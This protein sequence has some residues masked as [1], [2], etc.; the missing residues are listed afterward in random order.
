MTIDILRQKSALGV[1][2]K[3]KLYVNERILGMPLRRRKWSSFCIVSSEQI[4]TSTTEIDVS[5]RA[6][7][8]SQ[9]LTLSPT[10]TRKSW[11]LETFIAKIKLRIRQEVRGWSLGHDECV[12][13]IL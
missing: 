9:H 8:H 2:L 7:I 6:K 3:T 4:C 12:T 5:C 10:K 11:R 1:T 13:I